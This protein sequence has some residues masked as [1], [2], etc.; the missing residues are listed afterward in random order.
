MNNYSRCWAEDVLT[1]IGHNY[2]DKNA[3]SWILR[4]M[5]RNWL[6]PEEESV[7]SMSDK[8]RQDFATYIQKRKM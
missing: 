7:T 3:V 6:E 2:Q 1:E 8:C 4:W 5:A